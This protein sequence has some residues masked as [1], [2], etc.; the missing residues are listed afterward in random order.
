MKHVGVSV[1]CQTP[2]EAVVFY[3]Q[4]S[5]RSIS[6][7]NLV[8]YT[9]LDTWTQTK[10][11]RS[12]FFVKKYLKTKSSKLQVTEDG[13]QPLNSWTVSSF[14]QL[15]ASMSPCVLMPGVIQPIRF[16]IC[17]YIIEMGLKAISYL[18]LFVQA[19]YGYFICMKLM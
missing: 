10:C 14:D 18:M 4:T 9:V 2:T 17:E 5:S 19:V 12:C 8:Q 15:E 16:Y 3:S 7:K 13:R 6:V 1:K 11:D